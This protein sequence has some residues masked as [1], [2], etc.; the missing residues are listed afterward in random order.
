MKV[1]CLVFHIGPAH[2]TQAGIKHRLFFLAS[3]ERLSLPSEP[4]C[5]LKGARE[6]ISNLNLVTVVVG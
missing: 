2:Q 5:F 3:D 4:Y 1:G 6:A